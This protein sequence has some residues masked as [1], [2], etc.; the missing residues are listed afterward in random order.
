M[1]LLT[2][3]QMVVAVAVGCILGVLA[4]LGSMA[5]DVRANEKKEKYKV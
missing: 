2:P 3:E 4:F 5:W 1:K